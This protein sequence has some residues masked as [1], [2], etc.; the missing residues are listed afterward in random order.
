MSRSTSSAGGFDVS[1]P[2]K[3]LQLSYMEEIVC[4]KD[5]LIF[6]ALFANEVTLVLW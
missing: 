1:E 5:D 3:V 2:A 4:N 6:D